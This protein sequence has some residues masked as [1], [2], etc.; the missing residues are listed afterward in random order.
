MWLTVVLL[1]G[2]VYFVVTAGVAF[3]LQL[4]A[5]RRRDRAERRRL[6]QYGT[7][8]TILIPVRRPAR[9]ELA[10]ALLDSGDLG[11]IDLDEARRARS[12]NTTWDDPE[13]YAIQG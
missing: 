7:A 13:R 10:Q 1:V 12:T 8:E 2:M 9:S 4:A 6:A 11:V 5:W 3:V